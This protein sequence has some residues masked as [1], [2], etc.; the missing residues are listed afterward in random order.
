MRYIIKGTEFAPPLLVEAYDTRQSD[1]RTYVHAVN[2]T[3][4]PAQ[5]LIE[6]DGAGRHYLAQP[7]AVIARGDK[8]TD[9][10]YRKL[11]DAWKGWRSMQDAEN[12]RHALE[13]GRLAQIYANAQARLLGTTRRGRAAKTA[14]A[15][16]RASVR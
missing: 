5:S 1:G 7:D 9:V 10:L 16:A 3:L 11:V 12:E 13:R 6:T 2:P 15:G 8:A 4:I 14:A